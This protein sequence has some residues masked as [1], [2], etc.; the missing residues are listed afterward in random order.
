MIEFGK[1]VMRIFFS[2]SQGGYKDF[3]FSGI[4]CNAYQ[5]Q[6]DR[7]RIELQLSASG[8]GGGGDMKHDHL[9]TMPRLHELADNLPFFAGDP[10]AEFAL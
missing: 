3:G 8:G 2:I 1:E 9:F 6:S 7:L 5:A 4:E 10:G